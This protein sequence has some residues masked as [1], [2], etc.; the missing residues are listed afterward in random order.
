[1]R[2]WEKKCRHILFFQL[3]LH[4][5]LEQTHENLQ[6][7]EYQ[8]GLTDARYSP[9]KGLCAEDT[10]FHRLG[11]GTM[12]VSTNNC[13]E[14][15]R[16]ECLYVECSYFCL[17]RLIV[18]FF[19]FFLLMLKH[20]I[21]GLWNTFIQLLNRHFSET[22]SPAKG[23]VY[24]VCCLAYLLL[25]LSA[26]SLRLTVI[27]LWFYLNFNQWKD[28][29]GIYR[30]NEK[31]CDLPDFGFFFNVCGTFC[32]MWREM[33]RWYDFEIASRSLFQHLF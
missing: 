18:W 23:G 32:R 2:T 31:D 14:E 1:M 26:Q 33:R 22:C 7:F 17:G 28:G 24:S 4:L 16:Q 30:K 19:K 29:L 10:R 12:P 3:C 8:A 15:A 21:V 11:D 5:H 6:K 20:W 13:L 25:Q 9:H 27:M